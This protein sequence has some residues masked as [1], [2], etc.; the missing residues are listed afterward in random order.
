MYSSWLLD[1]DQ[2]TENIGKYCYI[3][4]L[5]CFF[6]HNSVSH[7]SLFINTESFLLFTQDSTV[8]MLLALN[9]PPMDIL[10]YPQF[11]VITRLQEITK[12]K[13]HLTQRLVAMQNKLSK[14]EFRI[15]EICLSS[16]HKNWQPP[17]RLHQFIHPITMCECALCQPCGANL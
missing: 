12:Y 17:K 2:A 13:H 16:F 8:W 3:Y 4:F 6:Q 10:D 1:I 5:P 7:R 15:K 14:L 9:Q 11:V